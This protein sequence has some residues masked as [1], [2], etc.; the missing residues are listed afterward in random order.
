[1]TSMTR[2][3]IL[4][5]VLIIAP[6]S[7]AKADNDVGCGVGTEIWKGNSGLEFKLMA[8]FT[9]SFLFQSISVTF[10]L[11]NCDGRGTVTASARTRHYVSS[12]LDRIA[13]DSA[14]GGG[15]SLDTLATLLDVP[16]M[17]RLAFADLAQ[18]HFDVLFPT[19][20]VTSDEMLQTLARLMRED[21][22]LSAN[23]RS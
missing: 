13:R 4:A 11:I 20:N 19:D 10:G 21:E 6:M 5:L 2:V 16:V 3:I 17:D 12:Q 7:V 22:Q 1:M 15:E 9:N 14:I 8:S 23:A 18:T